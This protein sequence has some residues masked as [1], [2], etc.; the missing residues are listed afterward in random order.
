VLVEVAVAEALK[1]PEAVSEPDMDCVLV[2]VAVDVAVAVDDAVGVAVALA[3]ANATPVLSSTS[4]RY[5]VAVS[6][7]EII[8]NMSPASANV[9]LTSGTELSPFAAVTTASPPPSVSSRKTNRI[10]GF[11]GLARTLVS[12]DAPVVISQTKRSALG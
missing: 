4:Q 8:D 12:F 2:D 5:V 6:D 1:V 11:V 7:T 10:P 9:A 3:V